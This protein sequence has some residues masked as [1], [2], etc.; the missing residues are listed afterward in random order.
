M[1]IV[2]ER[3]EP[4]GPI[5]DEDA[6]I[7]FN[8][9]ADRGREMTDGPDR[10]QLE[11]PS[12]SLAPKNLHFTTMTQYDKSFRF[13]SCCRASTPDNILADVMAQLQLEEPARRRDG[14]V[15]ACDVLLQRRK[16]EAVSREKN[17][18][19]CHRPRSPPTI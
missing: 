16:R 10:C 13:R 8:F 12:R 9:R 6:C 18:K 1:T 11:Q 19:W 2:D 4:V 5:R 7:F 3:N 15:R 17:A 14:K